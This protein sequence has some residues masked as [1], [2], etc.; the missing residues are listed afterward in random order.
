MHICKIYVNKYIYMYIC[1]YAYVN[2]YICMYVYM[3]VYVQIHIYV[4]VMHVSRRF[5]IDVCVWRIYIKFNVYIYI[6]L[7]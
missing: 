7:Y 3:H 1:L 6:Y 5:Y 4:H 2:M